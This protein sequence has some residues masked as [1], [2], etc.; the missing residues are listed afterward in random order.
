MC[1]AI[2]TNLLP[3]FLTTFGETFGGQAGLTEEQL[4][5][6]PALVFCGFLTGIAVTG[7]LADRWGGKKFVLG[8]LVAICVGLVMLAAAWQYG[9]LL[10]SAFLMGFGSGMLEVI[11]SP[12]V[13]ALQPHRR[14]TAL[15]WLHSFYCIGAVCTVLIGS[16]GLYLHVPWRAVALGIIA[17]PTFFLLCFLPITLPPMVH[18][19]AESES[20]RSLIGHK[21]LLATLVLI[22]LGGATELGMAQWLPAHAERG[23]GYTKGAA[24]LVLVAFSLAMVAGRVSFGFIVHHMHGT[25]LMITCCSLSA[26]LIPVA[27]FVHFTPVVLAACVALGFLVS[28]F[29]PTSLGLAGDRFPG[30]GASMYALLAIFGNTGCMVVPWLV[31]VVAERSSLSLGLAMVTVCPLAMTGILIWMRRQQKRVV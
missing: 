25:T 1:V 21:Y 9:T 11:L 26:A 16:A 13:A 24:A 3:V 2:A 18:E 6:I 12:I 30:G 17:V 20:L 27:A 8:G 22:C 31:G 4:G 10:A 15:S 14:T 23:L 7:P 29:W 28:C 19:D 5:R